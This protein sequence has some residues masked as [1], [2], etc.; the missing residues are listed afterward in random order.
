M[1]H[2]VCKRIYLIYQCFVTPVG[3]ILTF[4]KNI[5]HLSKI[6]V[7]SRSY[8]KIIIENKTLQCKFIT[9]EKVLL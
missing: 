2:T 6:F 5:Q 1:I 4:T 7:M 9:L 3:H 8:K